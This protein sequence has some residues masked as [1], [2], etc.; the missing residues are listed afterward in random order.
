MTAPSS[1]PLRITIAGASSLLGKEVT[2]LMASSGLPAH[3]LRLL[4]DAA[5]EG[6]LTEAE[7]EPALIRGLLP[8]SFDDARL[9]FFA[10]LEEFTA[11]HWGEAERAG[12]DV[13]DLSGGL[14]G[15]RR[16]L[17]SI[18]S[19]DDTLSPARPLARK[20]VRAPGAS[21]IVAA[22]V[23]VA[24]RMLPVRRIAA[25]IFHSVSESGQAGIDE[26]EAQTAS[27]LSFQPIAR[28][29]FDAQVAFNL[30]DRYGESCRERLED[31]RARISRD[32][33]DYLGYRAPMP[34]VQVIQAPVFYGAAFSVGVEFDGPLP[35]DSVHDA[36]AGVGVVVGADSPSNTSVAGSAEI[37]VTLRADANLP[38]IWWIWGAVDNV[39]LA[40][41]NAVR[42]AERICASE[43]GSQPA[44]A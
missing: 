18:A 1:A 32:L 24:L 6:T 12:A 9:V 14:S 3:E 43:N 20:L 21:V 15:V 16:A 39:R 4:D 44:V 31:V 37:H 36:L 42:I 2:E 17:P 8:G 28:E 11:R 33:A 19:L 23:A 38:M 35:E 40:A 30:L 13:I 26:L 34:A 27:L 22:T 10:G 29:V 7:G 5:L 25:T 41:Q